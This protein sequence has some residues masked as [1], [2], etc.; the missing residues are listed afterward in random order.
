[1]ETEDL[2]QQNTTDVENIVLE[3]VYTFASVNT[4]VT[5]S[6]LIS[7][8]TKSS[9]GRSINIKGVERRGPASGSHAPTGDHFM[10]DDGCS[11]RLKGLG[12]LECLRSP[13]AFG[14]WKETMAVNREDSEKCLRSPAAFGNWKETMAVNREDRY[15]QGQGR[16]VCPPA[17]VSPATAGV[18]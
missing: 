6:H 1:M 17:N 2:P 16:V 13:A 11:G 15:D 18:R 4:F 10:D 3:D 14:N 7:A 8:T 5:T 12:K 9:Q